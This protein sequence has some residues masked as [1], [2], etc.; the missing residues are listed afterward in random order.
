MFLFYL[1]LAGPS[2]TL[3]IPHDD[4][5]QTWA[6]PRLSVYFLRFLFWF[7][8][9]MLRYLGSPVQARQYKQWRSILILSNYIRSL[10]ERYRQQHN[11]T[12]T[13]LSA[14]NKQYQPQ[15]EPH[16]HCIFYIDQHRTDIKIS[17]I[18]WRPMHD[19]FHMLYI[20]YYTVV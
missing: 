19:L 17:L 6:R 18:R 14:I 12:F 10:R 7:C 2:I 8:V 5:Y 4:C 3:D 1:T 15:P 20:I 9:L 16:T 13:L 11:T